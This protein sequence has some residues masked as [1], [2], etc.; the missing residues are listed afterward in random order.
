MATWFSNKS[1]NKIDLDK[2]KVDNKD[3]NRKNLKKE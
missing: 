2:K 3:I 1:A